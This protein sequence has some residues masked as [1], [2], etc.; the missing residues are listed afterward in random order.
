M[1]GV[2]P[3]ALAGC[4]AWGSAEDLVGLADGAAVTSW[5]SRV[6]PS[7]DSTAGGTAPVFV[8]ASWA[9]MPG[10]RFTAGSVLRR[11]SGMPAGFL[12]SAA[13]G[14]VLVFARSR[15]ASQTS[16]LLTVSTATSWAA[17]VA[18]RLAAASGTSYIGAAGRRLD[19][20]TVQSIAGGGT[21]QWSVLDALAPH[22][23]AVRVDHTAGRSQVMQDG[24]QVHGSSS[25][26]TTGVTSATGAAALSVGCATGDATSGFIGDVHEW[27]VFDRALTEGEIAQVSARWMQRYGLAPQ[28][29]APA[30]LPWDIDLAA[31][32]ASDRQTTGC[33]YSPIPVSRDNGSQPDDWARL[34]V[35]PDGTAVSNQAAIG[36][37]WRDRP[38]VRPVRPESNWWLKDHIDLAL[39][40]QARGLDGM[41]TDV[42]STTAESG[43]HWTWNR[44][45]AMAGLLTGFRVP[46]FLDGD[47][48][49]NNHTAAE[50][51]ALIAALDGFGSGWKLPDG[52][53]VIYVFAPELCALP[54]QTPV[55]TVSSPVDESC[56]MRVFFDAVDA[57]LRAL[58]ITPAWM[59]APISGWNNYKEALR[60]LAWA[61]S[62]W[63]AGNPYSSRNA[64]ADATTATADGFVWAQPVKP[65]DV[66][67]RDRIY[68]E[69]GGTQNLRAQIEG[70][71]TGGASI[72]NITT[73]GDWNESSGIEPS[74]GSPAGW[75][76][77]LSYWVAWWKLGSPPPI[78]REGVAVLHRKH[79][80]TA[81]PT[82]TRNT[83]LMAPRAGT[84]PRDDVEVCTWLTAPSQ[85]T[86]TVGSTTTV[87]TAPAGFSTRNVS[88]AAGQVS[89]AV[90]R[91]GVPVV[92]VTSPHTVTLTPTVQDPLRYQALAVADTPVIPDPVPAETGVAIARVFAGAG[93]RVVIERI[94]ADGTATRVLLSQVN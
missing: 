37:L 21:F 80:R 66:R 62:W 75:G 5:P 91:A 56:T 41:A 6:G 93:Q 85:V 70:A 63:G 59:F 3:D 71:I 58:G 68:D 69:S 60:G 67:P 77:L 15:Q 30:V 31:L 42:I 20:D 49:E 38:K 79:P 1:V 89:A 74:E 52:R 55:G 8:A 4:V 9:T 53:T 78:V 92:A 87:V 64:A 61:G 65:Q 14:T 28:P 18:L 34:F 46:F 2:D 16:T 35:S 43:R 90:T 72:L 88:L 81:T 45:H 94:N 40:M 26:L 32:K 19:A 12:A 48:W 47:G 44:V 51:A 76:S 33:W 86:V 29:A 57:E 17:R 36:G 73:V 84:S 50:T 24:V 7:L 10:V 22:A 23:L 27:A 25:W 54:G 39:W 83:S 82:D 13:G 11:V